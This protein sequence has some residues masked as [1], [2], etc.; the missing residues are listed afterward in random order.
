MP[1]RRVLAVI[2]QFGFMIEIVHYL[3]HLCKLSIINR[4]IITVISIPF[5][6][7]C[8]TC[9]HLFYVHNTTAAAKCK[10]Y[11]GRQQNL[12]DFIKFCHLAMESL[13]AS[14]SQKLTNPRYISHSHT[15]VCSNINLRI[16]KE[17]QN[18][19]LPK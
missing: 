16:Q 1:P 18:Q 3:G 4:L 12:G 2:P 17:F 8:S 10:L 6:F 19:I 14:N 9:V 5:S 13:P 15:D 7:F 11:Q